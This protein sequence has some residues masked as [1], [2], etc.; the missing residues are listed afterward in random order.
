MFDTL[1]K[2]IID[3][4]L[5]PVIYLLFALAVIYFFIGVIKFIKNSDSETERKVGLNH[6][7]WGIVGIF[8]MLSARGLINIILATFGLK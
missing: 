2:N 8:I 1:F 4:I 7:I 5:N 3:N 6:I